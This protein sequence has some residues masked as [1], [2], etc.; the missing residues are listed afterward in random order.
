MG[1]KNRKEILKKKT[2]DQTPQR[3]ESFLLH[4]PIIHIRLKS[5]DELDHIEGREYNYCYYTL[6]LFNANSSFTIECF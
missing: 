6:L 1:I 4:S 3:R 2:Y 5:S